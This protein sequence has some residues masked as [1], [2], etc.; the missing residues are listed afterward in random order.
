MPSTRFM[1]VWVGKRYASR[2]VYHLDFNCP[3]LAETDPDRIRIRR[4]KYNEPRLTKYRP[5]KVCA[6]EP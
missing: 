6:C 2:Q 4:P 3:K 1:Q 5:C